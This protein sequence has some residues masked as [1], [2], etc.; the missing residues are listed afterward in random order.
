MDVTIRTFVDDADDCFDVVHHAAT[1]AATRALA[2]PS[3]LIWVDVLDPTEAEFAPFV[4]TM[5]LDKLA[6]EDALTVHERP[7]SLRYGEILFVTAYTVAEDGATSRLSLFLFEHG[8]LTV[9]LGEGFPVDDVAEN[10]SDNADLLQYGPKSLEL[11]LLDA[12]VD[13]YTARV[14]AVDER[15]DDVESILFD[16]RSSDRVS[17]VTFDLHKQVGELRRIVLPMRDVVGSVLRRVSAAPDLHD[18]L[19][20][21]E[22]VYDHTMRAADWTEGLRDNV[23]SVRSTNLA[24]VDNQLNTVMKKLTSWAAIIAVPTAITGYFGQNVPYPGFGKEWGFWLSLLMMLT[25][26]GGLYA[27]FKR[28]GWL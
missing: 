3:G 14:T 18:L 21:A 22:D 24:L 1:D 20:Y 8:V 25:L 9:R 27:A 5:G 13:G 26:A 15:L 16:G 11:M 6:V 2:A 19:P 12:V 17:Q 7:K 10:I 28:R 4:Q 23:E